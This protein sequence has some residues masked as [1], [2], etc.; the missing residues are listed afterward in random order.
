MSSLS[1]RIIP[2]EWWENLRREWLEEIEEDALYMLSTGM[3]G[4]NY[5]EVEEFSDEEDSDEYLVEG[6]E[7]LFVDHN[8]EYGRDYD[9]EYDYGYE[10]AEF[11]LENE[12][13][14]YWELID[15]DV[16]E[17]E[18]YVEYEPSWLA[19]HPKNDY[20]DVYHNL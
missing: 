4:R 11:D 1:P 6:E 8:F 19:P 9:Y 10:G 2:A 17:D 16:S 13:E 12:E 15:E 20:D 18:G 3:L 5:V 7:E 14:E